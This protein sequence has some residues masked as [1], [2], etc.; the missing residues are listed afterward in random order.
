MECNFEYCQLTDFLYQIKLS[1][2]A[3]IENNKRQKNL[4]QKTI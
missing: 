2:M 3:K 1:T 4:E